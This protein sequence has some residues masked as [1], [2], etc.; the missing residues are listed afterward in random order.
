MFRIEIDSLGEVRVPVESLYGAQTQRAVENFPI[1]GLRFP[2]AFLRALGMIKCASALVNRELGLLEPTMAIAIAESAQEVSDGNHDDQFPLDIFQTG[3]GT[4][5]NMNANE[6]IARLATQRLGDKVHPNDHVNL[7]QS[8]NDVIPSAIHISAYEEV[9][10]KLFPSLERLYRSICDK[11][12]SLDH[13]VKTGRTH[14]MDAVP[15]RMAQELS[16]WSFQLLQGMERVTSSLPRLAALALGGTAVGTSFNAHPEFGTRTAALLAKQTGLPLKSS[17]NYFAS[18]SSQDTA[19]ELSGH[20]KTI[21]VSLM[22][23]SNDLRWMN[24]GPY[25]GLGEISLPVLQPGSSMMP[26]KVNP[27]IPEAVAMVCAQVIG[28]DLTVTVAGQSGNF[29]INVMLPVIGHNLLQSIGLLANAAG[30]LADKA[31]RD[32]RVNEARLASLSE[33]SPILATALTTLIGYDKAAQI[34]ARARTEQR[35]LK[36]VAKAMTDLPS[37]ELERLL[38]PRRMTKGGFP[39]K[40]F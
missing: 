34:G 32:F 10:D 8:S 9:N 7:C 4:S 14:L 36:D 15:I 40:S 26:D 11:A 35:V 3:S 19:V 2:R 17:S 28:N 1:S 20:L 39:D 18:I 6:V 22:K 13:V 21:A 12:A 23:I 38:D 24:S 30:L 27:V 25:A 5:T 31:I 29:Q 33:R 37:D 16:G